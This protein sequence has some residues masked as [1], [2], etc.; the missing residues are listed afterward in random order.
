MRSERPTLFG[1]VDWGSE[2]HSACVVGPDGTVVREKVF[3][4]GRPRL[5]AIADW[6]AGDEAAGDVPVAIKV[7]HGPIVETP[8]DRGHPVHTVN[9]KQLDRFRDRFSPAGAKDDGRDARVLADAPKTD[10][11]RLRNRTFRLSRVRQA[12][13]TSYPL[14]TGTMRNLTGSSRGSWPPL[15]PKHVTNA[16]RRAPNATVQAPTIFMSNTQVKGFPIDAAIAA[17]HKRPAPTIPRSAITQKTRSSYPCGAA[18]AIAKSGVG[19]HSANAAATVAGETGSGSGTGDHVL[20]SRALNPTGPSR[21]AIAK[22]RAALLLRALPRVTTAT[23]PA[24]R[25]AP[26]KQKPSTR[27]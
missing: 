1:G 2:T 17:I 8:M 20:A 26:N 21:S 6:L 3:R 16:R 10:G 27:Q 14:G 4:H 13:L 24:I 25:N 19:T 7:P 9:P 15:S 18:G 23:A 22:D 5:A 12:Q 11:H